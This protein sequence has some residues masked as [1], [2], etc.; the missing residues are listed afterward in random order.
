MPPGTLLQC[1]CGCAR[2]VPT[3]SRDEDGDV[4]I[5]RNFFGL[6]SIEEFRKIHERCRQ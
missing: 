5:D 2:W 3:V 4:R 6:N 1:V